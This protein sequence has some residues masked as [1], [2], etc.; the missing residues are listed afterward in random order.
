MKHLK[1]RRSFL[2][3]IVFFVATIAIVSLKRPMIVSSAATPT[4]TIT[5]TPTITPTP[6]VLPTDTPTPTAT[7]LPIAALK[8]GTQIRTDIACRGEWVRVTA[9]DGRDTNFRARLDV[10]V[11]WE[12]DQIDPNQRVIWKNPPTI[13]LGTMEWEEASL[14]NPQQISFGRN[15]T[16]TINRTPSGEKPTVTGDTVD[17]RII[18]DVQWSKVTISIK[19]EVTLENLKT[20][21]DYVVRDIA[22]M[23]KLPTEGQSTDQL[24]E[25]IADVLRRENVTLKYVDSSPITVYE[26]QK[27]FDTVLLTSTCKLALDP[28]ATLPFR[29]S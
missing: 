11:V 17:G 8:A 6:T 4:A 22:T 2:V 19:R 18:L 23:L 27:K 12:V 3:F 15:T 5:F 25:A 29:A 1:L 7:I 26:E 9:P 16:R 21:N 13:L 24:R 10:A 20:S 28:P 14:S